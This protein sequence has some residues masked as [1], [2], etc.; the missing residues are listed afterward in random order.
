MKKIIKSCWG[1]VPF[2]IFL[3]CIFLVAIVQTTSD[4]T[5][6]I[7]PRN[8]LI[9]FGIGS[10]GILLLWGNLKFSAFCEYIDKTV[11]RFISALAKALSIFGFALLVLISLF[12]MGLSHRPEHIV[13]RNGIKMVASVNSFLDVKVY[14]YQYKNWLFY[15]RQLG[16]EYYGSGGYDPFLETSAEPPIEWCFYD[17]EGNIINTG[18]NEDTY[19]PDGTTQQPSSEEILRQKAEI[20]ELNIGVL[21]N[22][23]DELVFS[24]SIEDFIDSYNGYYWKDKNSRYLLPSSEWR[25]F[26][27]DT[28]IHSDHETFYYN[29]TADEKVWSLPTISV[30]APTNADYIQ[31]ITVNFDEHS[32]TESLYESYEEMCFYTLKVFFPDLSDEKIVD[33][34][35]EANRLGNINV[36]SSENWYDTGAVPYALFYKDGI[37]VYPYFAIGDWQRLCIIP[38]TQETLNEFEEKGVNIFEIK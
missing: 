9:C 38:I 30:Y 33:L 28:G 11:L 14:Y 31:E 13:T 10:L 22:R 21:N 6:R 18:S 23:E 26:T 7:L 20:K 16:H 34:Y 36:F 17:L 19:L 4:N 2:A 5:L 12:Y 8:L 37:G 24:I 15:G 32:Y 35:K 1:C 25:C 29:F 27:Y 3:L